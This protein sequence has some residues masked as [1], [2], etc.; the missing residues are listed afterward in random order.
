MPKSPHNKRLQICT[1]FEIIFLL[2]WKF[3]KTKRLVIILFGL[4]DLFII[5]IGFLEHLELL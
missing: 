5:F 2:G 1:N 4:E 3:Q